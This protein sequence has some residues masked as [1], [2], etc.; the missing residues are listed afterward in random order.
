MAKF[1]VGDGQRM[2]LE[3]LKKLPP[4]SRQAL[5]VYA[6]PLCCEVP[7]LAIVWCSTETANAELK[8]RQE[9]ALDAIR[10]AE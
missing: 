6:A 1:L 3:S 2:A 4:R 10:D 5:R 7:L 9:G 8:A